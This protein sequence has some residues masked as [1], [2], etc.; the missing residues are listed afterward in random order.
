MPSGLAA[1]V[2]KEINALSARVQW[3]APQFENGLITHYYLRVYK[4]QSSGSPTE[5]QKMD[6]SDVSETLINNLSPATVHQV[7]IE[8]FTSAGGIESSP[9]VF[10]TKPSCKLT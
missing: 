6:V 10:T 2:A 7:T 8:A 3:T 5:T 9:L 4:M 1:P